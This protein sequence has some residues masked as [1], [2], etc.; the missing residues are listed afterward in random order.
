MS[1]GLG[2]AWRSE[3]TNLS[4]AIKRRNG[5]EDDVAAVDANHI[6]KHRKKEVHDVSLDESP[7]RPITENQ[8]LLIND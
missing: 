5:E 7:S 6:G 4:S 1:N 3:P 2:P 8:V